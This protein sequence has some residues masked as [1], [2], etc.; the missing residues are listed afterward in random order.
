MEKLLKDVHW[1]PSL[2]HT[3]E[4]VWYFDFYILPI[5]IHV[6]ELTTAIVLC[7]EANYNLLTAT[8]QAYRAR[9][10][11]TQNRDFVMAYHFK[12]T[13]TFSSMT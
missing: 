11:H 10:F 4:G 2:E 3:G 7:G 12:F 9:V 5:G 6:S 8:F 13:Q 1:F